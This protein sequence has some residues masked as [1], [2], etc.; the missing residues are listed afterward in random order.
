MAC[1]HL[2]R[3]DTEW[4]RDSGALQLGLDYATAHL[5]RGNRLLA[6]HGR[7]LTDD[8]EQRE[9]DQGLGLHE[10]DLLAE[11]PVGGVAIRRDKRR[12]HGSAGARRQHQLLLPN[13]S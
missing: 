10:D 7:V 3:R 6:R 12:L 11:L 8:R 4:F 2:P 13:L 9:F 5:W 1:R